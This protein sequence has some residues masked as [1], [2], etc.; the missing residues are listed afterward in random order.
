MG[1]TVKIEKS[2]VGVVTADISISFY[3]YG[4]DDTKICTKQRAN[5]ANN[6]LRQVIVSGTVKIC[7]IICFNIA[8]GYIYLAP[9][10]SQSVRFPLRNNDCCAWVSEWASSSSCAFCPNGHKA[11]W[12]HN[13]PGSRRCK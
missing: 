4:K 1:D 13:C 11:E 7:F 12:P 2:F 5:Y 10:G 8:S 9:G 3:E 6:A